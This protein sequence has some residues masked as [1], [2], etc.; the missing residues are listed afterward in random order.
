MANRHTG[1]KAT[2]ELTGSVEVPGAM[3]S[4]GDVML[5]E[6]FNHT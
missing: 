4:F 6:S 5:E 2:M 3:T 1:H